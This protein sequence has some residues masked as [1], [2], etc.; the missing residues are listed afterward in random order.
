LL[1]EVDDL[2]KGALKNID[3]PALPDA[4]QA[5]VAGQLL[6]QGVA[7]VPAMDQVETR[8]FSDLPLEAD[9]VDEQ[10]QLVLAVAEDDRDD[11]WPPALGVQRSRPLADEVQSSVAAKWR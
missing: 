7:E 2:Y 5:G 9:A 1:P 8:G 10:D 3:R 11:V 6:V 4:G